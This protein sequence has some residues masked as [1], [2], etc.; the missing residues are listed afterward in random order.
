MQTILI[1]AT[2][3]ADG[4]SFRSTITADIGS[5]FPRV[6]YNLLIS[7]R[8]HAAPATQPPTLTPLSLECTAQFNRMTQEIC[9]NCT[10]SRNVASLDFECSLNGQLITD[11]CELFHNYTQATNFGIEFISHMVLFQ[12]ENSRS[13]CLLLDSPRECRPS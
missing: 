1:V 6:F 5:E 4:A 7:T 3:S 12:V 8:S 9:V 11:G 13:V 2:D 10:S